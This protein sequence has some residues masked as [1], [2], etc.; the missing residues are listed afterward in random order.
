M[1]KQFV[2]LNTI[3]TY[4]HTCLRLPPLFTENAAC[5]QEERGGSGETHHPVAQRRQQQTPQQNVTPPR[6][7]APSSLEPKR[8]DMDLLYMN[9]WFLCKKKDSPRTLCH[10]LCTRSWQWHSFCVRNKHYRY[11]LRL[12]RLQ[13]RAFFRIDLNNIYDWHRNIATKNVKHKKK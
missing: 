8:K 12:T 2:I 13:I 7:I 5:E 11:C 3:F 6:G 1:Q 9:A 4:D 10:I